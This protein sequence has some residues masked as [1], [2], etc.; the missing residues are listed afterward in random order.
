M[1]VSPQC[2]A[3]SQWQ[4]K[5]EGC[6]L[7]MHRHT[8]GHWGQLQSPEHAHVLVDTVPGVRMGHVRMH[9]SACPCPRG[10]WDI[11][12]GTVVL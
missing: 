4:L 3:P 6:L 5:L 7:N 9:G 10:T 11:L 12:C 1:W 8:T 2:S